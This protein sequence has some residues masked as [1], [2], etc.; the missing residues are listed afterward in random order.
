MVDTNSEV[1]EVEEKILEV[2]CDVFLKYGIN[3]ATMKQIAEG[4][5]ISRTLLNYYYR[6]K[7]H[8]IQKFLII[9]ENKIIPA[10]SNIIEDEN[11]TVLMKIE[12][13][14]DEY[15]GLISKYPMIPS[16]MLS[17]TTRDPNW[18][19]KFFKQKAINFQKFSSQIE[20]EISQGKINPFKL[21]E[22]FVNILGLCAFPLLSKPI[23]IEF[24]FNSNENEFN[25]FMESRKQAVKLMI[26]NWLKAS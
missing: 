12:L 17:E 20:A 21:E 4:A 10:V 3:Q 16:F 15:I 7:K 22:L 11:L 26:N 19:I 1:T 24:F 13:F 6:S 25:K 2:A 9:I 23:L 18:V 8:L 14:I 5:G